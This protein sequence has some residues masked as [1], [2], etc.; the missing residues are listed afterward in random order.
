MA[1]ASRIAQLVTVAGPP[2]V[3]TAAEIAETI[4]NEALTLAY[5]GFADAPSDGDLQKLLACPAFA[6]HVK[7][8]LAIAIANVLGTYDRRVLSVHYVYNTAP[9]PD[10]AVDPDAPGDP[11]LHFLVLVTSPT[12]ALQAF[13]KALDRALVE[14]MRQLPSPSLASLSTI[15]DVTLA[16]EDESS[17]GTG[18]TALLRSTFAPPVQLWKREP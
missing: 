11:L 7:Y 15:L 10:A 17:R 2:E 13:V 4:R 16:T 3:S 6:N 5:K 14:S 8:R 18:W 12:A 1:V 9:D